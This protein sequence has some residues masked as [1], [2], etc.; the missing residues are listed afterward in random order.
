MSG[1]SKWAQIKRQ[2]GVTDQKRGQA[3]TKLGNIITIAVREG[4][5]VTD[6]DQNFRLRIAVDQARAINMPKENIQR[7][8]ERGKGRG[9]KGD[10]LETVYEGFA[11]GGTT[12]IVE[13]TTDNKLRTNSEVKNVIEKNGGTLGNP[14]SVS[15]LFSQLGMITLDKNGKSFDDLFLLTIDAGAEDV[16]ESGDKVLVYTKVE[17]LNSVRENL[18]KEGLKIEG[19]EITRKPLQPVVVESREVAQKI[20]NLFEK[21]ESMDDVSKVYSSSDIPEEFLL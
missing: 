15:Y 21:L 11:P 3:F 19:F 18:L 5:G 17:N 7:A 1:H 10:L 8:I 13:A 12:I 9:D 4:G 2:K 6:P 16:E 20:L 14:G